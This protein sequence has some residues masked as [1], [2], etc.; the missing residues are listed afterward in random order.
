MGDPLVLA[1]RFYVTSVRL[2]SGERVDP[3]NVELPSAFVLDD[4]KK[5][6]VNQYECYAPTEN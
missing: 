1:P 3:R 6:I 4:D 5:T 2:P